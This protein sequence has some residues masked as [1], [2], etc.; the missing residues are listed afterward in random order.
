M[1]DYFLIKCDDRTQPSVKSKYI[2]KNA[3]CFSD[4]NYFYVYNEKKNMFIK[5]KSD[6]HSDNL[7]IK[8]EKN[9]FIGVCFSNGYY[10]VTK[11]SL[12]GTIISLKDLNIDGVF[13]SSNND[14]YIRKTNKNLGC[15]FNKTNYVNL[16]NY[17]ENLEE[18]YNTLPKPTKNSHVI[19]EYVC[20]DS[21]GK[22]S[23][24]NITAKLDKY[25]NTRDGSYKK[26][27]VLKIFYANIQICQKSWPL[28]H[29]PKS[30]LF[31]I[32][33]NIFLFF[34]KG[35]FKRFDKKIYM[36]KYYAMIMSNDKKTYLNCI[37]KDIQNIISEYIV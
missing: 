14:I 4:A 31:D 27:D 8:L 21:F 15:M 3:I 20:N 2:K 19:I 16:N 29:G 32:S 25:I 34:G 26:Y 12:T 9:G 11:Y 6:R 23:N 13:I 7:A 17:D 30:I 18:N 10:S 33:G 37:C 28:N 5:I 35:I 36:K 24:K 22:N 1:E